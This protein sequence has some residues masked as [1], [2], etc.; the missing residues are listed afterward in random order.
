MDVEITQIGHPRE[1]VALHRRQGS[2]P[3][4]ER[5]AVR[6]R[7]NFFLQ[8]IQGTLDG[9]ETGA[10]VSPYREAIPPDRLRV[11]GPQPAEMKGCVLNFSVC[12]RGLAH[13]RGVTP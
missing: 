10:Y 1:A 2:L 5:C 13:R 6:H 12:V 11:L 7:S 9:A 3:A 8:S 4:R